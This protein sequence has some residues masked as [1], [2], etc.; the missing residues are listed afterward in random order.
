MN[1]NNYLNNLNNESFIITEDKEIQKVTKIFKHILSKFK[2]SGK[3][4]AEVNKK[5]NE[6]QKTE[7]YKKVQLAIKNST[8]GNKFNESRFKKEISDLCD[9]AKVNFFT[10]IL[11]IYFSIKMN[12]SKIRGD[13][14]GF[15]LWLSLLFSALLQL[16][17]PIFVKLITKTERKLS[18]IHKEIQK[19]NTKLND[20]IGALSAILAV[21]SFLV[22][23]LYGGLIVSAI[24]TILTSLAKFVFSIYLGVKLNR[25]QYYE[26][27][28]KQKVNVES[29]YTS[30]DYI[31]T[32]I[33][34]SS[35]RENLV[36]LVTP[37][38]SKEF[39]LNQASDYEILHFVIEG[40]FPKVNEKNYEDLLEILNISLNTNFVPI[41][42]SNIS[43]RGIT[44]GI[45]LETII[46]NFTFSNIILNEATIDSNKLSDLEKLVKQAKRNMANAMKNNLANDNKETKTA[47]TNA[48]TAFNDA[49]E[50]YNQYKS[51]GI[52]PGKKAFSKGESYSRTN[53]Q[54]S[55]EWQSFIN[56]V[57]TF[58]PSGA[59][60]NILSKVYGASKLSKVANI[61]PALSGFLITLTGVVI[62]ST[63]IF[64]SYKA[65]QRLLGNAANFCRKE[66]VGKNTVICMK[67]F[68]LKGIKER[69]VDLKKILF[70]CDKLKKQ[71]QKPCKIT[72]QSKI[73]S[74][75]KELNELQSYLK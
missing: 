17:G 11:S 35:L 58:S 32:L 3:N 61:S 75:N 6:I 50:R 29:N 43:T 63:F 15:I 64:A 40:K 10:I 37:I 54:S 28:V 41:V 25:W 21:G 31:D 42:E 30:I 72:I 23:G 38:E 60:K 71:E 70:Y 69:I 67:K 9:Y 33:F 44:A 39:I 27:L 65:Y 56:K 36:S 13:S 19:S 68:E 18:D 73:N 62:A 51:T 57:Y 14:S 26:K 45:L 2:V 59:I 52:D 49:K 12:L 34:I 7:N 20:Q 47:Y 4:K 22:V 24:L 1:I 53:A 16:P 55:D 48:G 74:L 46:S 8:K 5:I 66:K